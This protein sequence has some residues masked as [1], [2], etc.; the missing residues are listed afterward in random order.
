[1]AKWDKIAYIQE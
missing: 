1:M